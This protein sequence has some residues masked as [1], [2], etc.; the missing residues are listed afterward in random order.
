[1]YDPEIDT[2]LNNEDQ[3]LFT[4]NA[5][6]QVLDATCTYV[7]TQH[8]D[9]RVVDLRYNAIPSPFQLDSGIVS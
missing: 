2:A 3:E 8:N 5:K 4:V 9:P 1:M 7:S 6:Y